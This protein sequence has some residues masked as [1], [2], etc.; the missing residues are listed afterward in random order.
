MF[1]GRW[2]RL[3]LPGAIAGLAAFGRLLGIAIP[4]PVGATVVLA[5]SIPIARRAYRSLTVERR[6]NLDV[7]D[8][9]AILLTTVRGSIMAPASVIGLVEIGEA[10]RERTARASR[11]ELLD[12]L[13]SIAESAW[14]ERD[15]ERRRVP[16]EE[17]RRGEVVVV[18]PGDRIPVDGRILD[19]SAFVDEHQ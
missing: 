18:Y 17:V 6:L 14:V 13:D 8:M 4:G 12:L 11:R 2:P 10:I 19:G 1:E 7:L 15:G 3:V 5:A 16:S 9:T